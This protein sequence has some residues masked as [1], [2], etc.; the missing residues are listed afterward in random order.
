MAR[1]AP[2]SRVAA[3]ESGSAGGPL[4]TEPALA[5]GAQ[6]DSAAARSEATRTTGQDQGLAI[7][8]GAE[9]EK[10]DG[11]LICLTQQVHLSPPSLSFTACA[12]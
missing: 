4:R 5:E 9:L 6:G 11:R 12:R 7:R 2:E 8:V 3:S 1:S 10:N